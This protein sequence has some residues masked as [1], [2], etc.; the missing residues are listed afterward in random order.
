M[1]PA[2]YAA[3]SRPKRRGRWRLALMLPAGLCLLAGLDAALILLDVPAPVQI[4]AWGPAHSLA[5]VFGFVG[6]LIALERA[7]AW[8]RAAGYAAPVLLA[9][10]GGSQLFAAPRALTGTTLIL[11]MATLLATYY[12]L[13]RRQ[14]ADAVLIQMLGACAGLGA[15]VL[16]A[17]GVEI[18][19]LL[20]WLAAFLVMTIAGERVELARIQLTSRSQAL[21]VVLNVALLMSAAAST[22]FVQ[23]GT[24]LFGLVLCALVLWLAVNDVARR[25]VKLK[26]APRYMAAC[27]LAGYFWLLVAG[28]VWMLGYPAGSGA[29]DTAVHAVF[30]GFVMSMIM[31]HAPTILP[32]VLAI[33]L[34]YRQA[35]WPPVI[36]MHAGLVIRLWLG[37]GLGGQLAWQ[38]GGVL[39]VVALLLFVFVALASA[40]LAL[41]SAPTSGKESVK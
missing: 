3:P 24:V 22:L 12:P 7:V 35:M 16:Y 1:S 10:G 36:L 33:D 18:S 9:L 27:L 13:W 6:A 21:A 4:A 30:L 39:N 11:G 37:N 2:S 23:A 41:T 31:A 17:G 20:P 14:R 29:Y 32:A 28:V 15:T 25:T 34:P 40:L 8:G 26:G 5:M 38:V 19:L